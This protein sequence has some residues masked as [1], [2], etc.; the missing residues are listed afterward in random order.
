M[1]AKEV[2]GGRTIPCYCPEIPG[3]TQA[4]YFMIL[5]PPQCSPASSDNDND[6]FFD[7]FAGDELLHFF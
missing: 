3:A 2:I 7:R 6:D 4:T 5:S 1:K